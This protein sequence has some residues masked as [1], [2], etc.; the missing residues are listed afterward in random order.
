MCINH[1]NKYSK[2]I[3]ARKSTYLTSPL[4]SRRDV[5]CGSSTYTVGYDGS[6]KPLYQYTNMQP[7]A[8]SDNIY[9]R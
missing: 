7:C 5:V 2:F 4:E 8:Y 9:M 6:F 1:A 3:A